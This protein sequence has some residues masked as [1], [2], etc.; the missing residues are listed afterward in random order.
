MDPM[1]SPLSADTMKENES[2]VS[3]VPRYQA[4]DLKDGPQ[5]TKEILSGRPSFIEVHFH[6]R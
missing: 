1:S 5:L 6:N 2:A 3:A 4:L